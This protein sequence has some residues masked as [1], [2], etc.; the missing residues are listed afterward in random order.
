MLYQANPIRSCDI[1]ELKHLEGFEDKI[2]FDK[3]EFSEHL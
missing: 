3:E 2:L 1:A